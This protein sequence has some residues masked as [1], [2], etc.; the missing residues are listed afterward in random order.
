MKRSFVAAMMTCAIALIPMADVYGQQTGNESG[1]RLA[2]TG[3]NFLSVSLSARAAGMGDAMTAQEGSAISMF[4]NPA[5]MA[6]MPAQAQVSVGQVQW[7]GETKYFYG[8]VAYRP[9]RGAYGTFGLFV[10]S[11]DYGEF[12]GTIRADNPSG[13]IDTGVFGPSALAVG[14]GYATNLSDRF[15]IGANIKYAR[16]SLGESVMRMGEDG[17][18]WQDNVE[19]TPAVDFGILYRTGFRSLLF[20]FNARNFSREVTYSEESMELPLTFGLGVSMDLM[21]LAQRSDD[22]HSMLVSVVAEH[23]RDYVEQLKI[24]GEYTFMNTLALRAG[25]VFPTDEQGISLGAGINTSV[26]GAQFGFD[27]GYT[28][29]GVFG[30]VNRFA[31]HLGIE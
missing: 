5:G 15:A 31:I 20:A 19:G 9:S 28:R 24:G 3:M 27:Y 29:F 23:P 7:I 14:M 12:I 18:E 17:M 25:Y 30:N 1:T 2:Q 21:S 8:S 22:T 10:T 26:R 13:Y 6:S 11:A 16:L 4:Y